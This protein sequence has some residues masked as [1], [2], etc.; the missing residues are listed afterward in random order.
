MTTSTV[1]KAL[2]K[3]TATAYALAK[4]SYANADKAWL[5]CTPTDMLIVGDALR[6]ARKSLTAADAAYAAARATR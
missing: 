6:A 3:E 2:V 5:A 4:I 1:T